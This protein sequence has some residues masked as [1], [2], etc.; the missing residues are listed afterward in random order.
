[1]K[2]PIFQRFEEEQLTTEEQ[3]KIQGGLEHRRRASKRKCGL[4]RKRSG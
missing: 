4:R 1:M 3:K 2:K